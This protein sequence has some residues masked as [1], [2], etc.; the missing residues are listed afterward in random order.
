VGRKSWMGLGAAI[1]VGAVSNVTAL[2]INA[3]SGIVGP[4]PA[5]LDVIRLHPFRWSIALTV[6]VPVSGAIVRQF[7]LYSRRKQDFPVPPAIGRP[8]WVVDRPNELDQVVG[9]LRR[10]T[11]NATI[12]ITT[13]LEGAGGFGKTTLARMVGADRRLRRRF[14]GRIFML[15]IGRDVR[16][17]ASIVAKVH[18]VMAAITGAEPAFTDNPE[19]AGNRL[20]ALLDRAPRILLILDDV[21]YPEQITPF[22]VG[23]KACSR[24]VTT[25]IP[26]I[27]LGADWSISVDQMSQDQA[28]ALLT[29]G[30]IGV[31]ASTLED[32]LAVTGKW[33][34]LLKL[35]NKILLAV[36]KS[37]TDIKVA[38]Q[39]IHG[40]LVSGGPQKVDAFSLEP[41]LP[42]DIDVPEQRAR[43]VEA[44]MVASTGLLDE[45]TRERFEEL[46]IFAEDEAIPLPLVATLWSASGGLSE[47]ESRLVCARL[48][49]LSLVSISP[50]GT[51]ALHDV[52]RDFIRAKVGA[53]RLAELHLTFLS[54]IARGLP[55][56]DAFP[57][58]DPEILRAAW[59]QL[60]DDD[61][62]LC[63]HL[64]EHHL[65]A[66]DVAQAEAIAVDLRWI[67]VQ[68][69]RFG[70]SRPLAELALVGTP[71]ALRCRETL[72][73]LV[74]L[75]APTKPADAVVDILYE[76]LSASEEWRGAVSTLADQRPVPRLRSRWRSIGRGGPVSSQSSSRRP[77]YV[78]ALAQAGDW[79]AEGGDGGAIR[80]R[81]LLT[82]VVCRTLNGCAHSV[83]SLASSSDGEW[84][85]SGGTQNAVSVWNLKTKK[86][87]GIL[88]GHTD[89]VQAVA[90][91]PDASWIVSGSND[92]TVRLWDA[93]SLQPRSSLVG[94][95]GWVRAV[96]V[97]PNGRWIASAGDDRTVR[98]WDVERG[99]NVATLRGHVRALHAIAIAPD[100]TWLASAGA[101]RTIM[102]WDCHTGEIVASLDGHAGL[103]RAV[104]VSADGMWLVS[105]DTE[106]EVRVWS[107]ST[108][109]DAAM[110]RVDGRLESCAWL[111]HVL[112]IGGSSASCA[113]EFVG[114]QLPAA[115]PTAVVKEA[116]RYKLFT[117]LRTR[118]WQGLHR[119]MAYALGRWIRRGVP[120]SRRERLMSRDDILRRLRLL[121]A[122]EAMILRNV[123]TSRRGSV[124]G[125]RRQ[126]S[127]VLRLLVL[128]VI[129]G[130]LCLTFHGLTAGVLVSSQGWVVWTCT[131]GFALMVLYLAHTVGT[132]LG[133]QRDG[134]N[135]QRYVLPLVGTLWVLMGTLMFAL[136]LQLVQD[137]RSAVAGESVVEYGRQR[138]AAALMFL[139]LYLAA[140]TIA[141]MSGYSYET[142]RVRLLRLR[143]NADQAMRAL[144]RIEITAN[145]GSSH[146]Q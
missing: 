129:A 29:Q 137:P 88:R 49:D 62:Y 32:L 75:L 112:A 122:E 21:W 139:C 46:A 5:G 36:A 86:L 142:V 138:L 9:A 77:D 12:G 90:F 15:T 58:A 26:S 87:H 47:L 101:D 116:G 103:V 65:A 117:R 28:V 136:Q 106:G 39:D 48:D 133:L 44:T 38:A 74:R 98:I 99:R 123:A 25:R 8:D 16:S 140:G 11:R 111:S 128:A 83:L 146:S 127:E 97:A 81:D 57:G 60:T 67:S 34:L 143:R 70:P 1:V 71:R 33:P 73:P 59:W 135:E 110:I 43:A 20:G 126:V 120:N 145:G 131:A 84:L 144:D 61:R 125:A 82:G 85:V 53:Q 22:L 124:D 78:R 68:L 114:P 51:L 100:G 134:L 115:D 10:N 40:L 2:T 118:R 45:L 108:Y 119:R 66:G 54:L 55:A 132:L 76:S 91:A 13:G 63:E 89:W 107:L 14:R 94:H 102:V 42:L 52:V 35:V 6:A 93:I 130:T 121:D 104:A 64:V 30:L 56:A 96:A 3:A 79:L 141:A 17:K 19:I 18:E 80:L 31:D 95:I 23:G 72:R 113:Y 105:A 37:T 24:L 7:N 69:V 41:G 109:S 4:W 50:D 92:G 27:V